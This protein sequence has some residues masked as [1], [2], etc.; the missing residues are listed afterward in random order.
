MGGSWPCC[1]SVRAF[2][3]SVHRCVRCGCMIQS[4]RSSS[5]VPH[6]CLTL[7]S[8]CLMS[9]CKCPLY[10]LYSI[11]GLVYLLPVRK[12]SM[13]EVLLVLCFVTQSFNVDFPIKANGYF[14]FRPRKDNLI[15]VG[16]ANG[17]LAVFPQS[18]LLYVSLILLCRG[19]LNALPDVHMFSLRSINTLYVLIIGMDSTTFKN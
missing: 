2:Y 6:C 8:V 9:A 17:T 18:D 13:T 16:L 11:K 5:T 14:Y 3:W 15:F 19:Y 1:P 4:D 12:E 7:Y 10:T